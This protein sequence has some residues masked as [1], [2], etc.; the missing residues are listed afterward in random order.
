MPKLNRRQVLR[1]MIYGGS[2]AAFG[3]LTTMGDMTKAHAENDPDNAVPERYYVFCYFSGAW[4][5]LLS[6]DPRDPAVFHNGNLATTRIQPGYDLLG[7]LNDPRIVPRINGG[8]EMMDMYDKPVHFGP[9]IGNLVNN[10]EL[11]SRLVVVRGMSMD[12]L[13]HQVGRRRFL[14]GKPPSGL[15]A[16]GSS[17]DTWLA[18]RLG[19]AEPLPNLAIRTESYNKGLSTSASALQAGSSDDLLRVLSPGA[20]QLDGLQEAQLDKLLQQHALCEQTRISDMLSDAEEARKKSRSMLSSELD[21]YFDFKAR[22]DDMAALRDRFN[23]QN[24]SSGNSPEVQAAIAGVALTRGVSRCVSIEAARGLDTHFDNWID[25]Q[26]PTQTRGFNAVANLAE[27][28]LETPYINKQGQEDGNWLDRT[29]IVGFSEFSR[30]PLINANSGRDHWLGNSCFLMGGGVKGGRVIGQS[31]DFGMYPQGVN[32]LTGELDEGGETIRP[33]HIIRAIYD[34]VGIGD[35]PDLRV[36][37]LSAIF[38]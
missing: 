25:T 33:E 9:F 26:G 16:R 35:E 37:G 7:Y 24:N 30:T 34:Q 19:G 23:I 15:T 17:T 29:L 36:D 31:S 1:S 13:T 14:T 32:L 27:Y 5:I 18:S 12:T 3:G 8:S 22:T 6:L 28:L 2:L 4:D 21:R 10:P 11:T 20:V 38:G